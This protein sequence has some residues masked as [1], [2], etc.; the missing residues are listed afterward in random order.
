VKIGP[1]TFDHATFDKQRD[2]LYLHGGPCPRGLRTLA[3]RRLTIINSECGIG[4]PACCGQPRRATIR[5]K[6]HLQAGG[7]SP[8]FTS[9]VSV[10]E[11]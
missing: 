11:A 9:H 10:G 6:W 2:V 3:R 4:S 5:A 7:Q 1:L 8:G